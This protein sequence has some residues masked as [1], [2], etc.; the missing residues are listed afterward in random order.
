VTE[1]PAGSPLR[2]LFD[3]NCGLCRRLAEYGR[4]R[5]EGVLE[6]IPWT[7]FAE[8]DEAA[9]LFTETERIAPPARLRALGGEGVLEDEAAWAA[10]LAAYPPFEKFAWIVERLGLLGAVSTAT[11]H[12][13]T[14]LRHRC[15]GCAG[16]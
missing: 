15:G 5:S 3:D 6:F 2:V 10:I 9:S 14:W 11:F 13:A 7:A 1:A 12:G 16:G 8:T 4:T